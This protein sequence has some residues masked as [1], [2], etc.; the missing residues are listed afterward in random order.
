MDFRQTTET[1]AQQL[2][3]NC[4]SG[5]DNN[6]C[7]QKLK[8][9]GVLF[10]NGRRGSNTVGGDT[11]TNITPITFFPDSSCMGNVISM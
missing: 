4:K 5:D 1:D 8:H 2:R 6:D 9:Q 3:R 10:Q 11:L 7:D